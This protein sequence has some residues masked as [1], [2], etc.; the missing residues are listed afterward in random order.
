MKTPP[1]TASFRPS[2]TEV[3]EATIAALGQADPSAV[4]GAVLDR[5]C[6]PDIASTL[7]EAIQLASLS[8]GAAFS[9]DSDRYLNPYESR[10]GAEIAVQAFVEEAQRGH[11]APCEQPPPEV[12]AARVGSI[13]YKPGWDFSLVRLSQTAVGVRVVASVADTRGAKPE[14][15]TTRVTQ[16]VGGDV[17]SAALRAIMQIEEHEARE[18]FHVGGQRVFDPHDGAIPEPP[19]RRPGA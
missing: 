18:L 2:L 1:E 15:R 3:L 14:F 17:A 5:L 9:I 11:A 8:A 12:L 6:E 13:R 7:V 10:V 19:N 16:I 4:A